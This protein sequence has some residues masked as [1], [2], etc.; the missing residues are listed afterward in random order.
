MECKMC[1]H[2]YCWVCG[3]SILNSS[4]H[5]THLE[6]LCQFWNSLIILSNNNNDSDIN[7]Y[8]DN[9]TSNSII[10]NSYIGYYLGPLIQISPKVTMCLVMAMGP[11]IAYILFAV[12]G[13]ALVIFSTMFIVATKDD[14][15][16]NK[17]KQ[18]L[19][20]SALLLQ[21]SCLYVVALFS[22]IFI[23]AYYY[24]ILAYFLFLLARKQFKS[25]T[26]NLRKNRISCEYRGFWA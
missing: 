9:M 20:F 10:F 25:R 17:L 2:K 19:L 18:M 14:C 8:Q 7:M 4:I 13:I 11:I 23:M 6:T 16:G 21:L 1:K 24:L 15:K 22:S 3:S 12:C 26:L 5:S